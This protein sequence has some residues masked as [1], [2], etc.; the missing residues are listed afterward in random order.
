[1]EQ[2]GPKPRMV[3]KIPLKK[4]IG[5]ILLLVLVLVLLVAF[6]VRNT[7][8]LFVPVLL[9]ISVIA[10]IYGLIANDKKIFIT[11]GAVSAIVI[12]AF[13]ALM[14][15]STSSLGIG[16]SKEIYQTNSM[17]I[18]TMAPALP[19]TGNNYRGGYGQPDIT[20]TREFLKV[21]YSAKIQTRDVSG[22]VK[23]VKGAVREA[24]GRIDSENTNDKSGYVSFVVPKSNF[25]NFRAEIENIIHKK[26]YTENVSAQNLLTQKQGIEVQMQAATSSLAALEQQKKN[27]DAQ[28]LKVINSIT[29]ELASIKSQL[30]VIEQTLLQTSDAT[31]LNVLYNQQSSLLTTQANLVNNKDIENRNYNSQNQSLVSQIGWAKNNV[32]Q[33]QQQDTEFGNNIETVSGYVDV[34]W[35]S[36]WSLAVLFSPIHPTIVIIVLVLALLFILNRKGYTPKIEFV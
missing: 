2:S 33:V 10:V 4:I 15:M 11:L 21:S 7:L 20:D 18:P 22:V 30:A 31:Q 28:H 14:S 16:S 19:P 27:L 6:D 35:I 24:K 29:K 5:V 17:S 13:L 25:E 34:S 23:D 36:M 12:I 1:M 3:I 26:L 32:G 8:S 9:I